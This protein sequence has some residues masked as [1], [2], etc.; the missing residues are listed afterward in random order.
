M[1][2]KHPIGGTYQIYCIFD[3]ESLDWPRFAGFPMVFHRMDGTVYAESGLN[4]PSP[5]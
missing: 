2:A 4:M 1:P 5:V 3:Q